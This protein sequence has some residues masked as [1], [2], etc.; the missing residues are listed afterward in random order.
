MK[1]L[2]TESDII[3][4]SGS[5]SKIFNVSKQTLLTPLAIDKARELGITIVRNTADELIK[6]APEAKSFD[7]GK[8][9]ICIGGDHTGYQ[10]KN[11]L[12][13][14]LKQK[15]Y[16]VFDVGTL[17]EQS[18]DYPDYAFEVAKKVALKEYRFGIL[19]DATGIPSA[20]TANKVPGIRAAT[21]YNEFSAKSAREHNN[22]N[23]LVVGAKSLGEETIKS[24]LDTWLQTEFGGERH[25]RRLDKINAIEEK[26]VKSRS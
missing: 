7:K 14:I 21:C 5:G 20:I 19:I 12:K 11:I 8:K 23:I 18:C 24:I 4:F 2:L 9:T 13:E 25:Q 3:S 1:K 10:I 26:F 17:S 22:A 6:G 16:E 15:S